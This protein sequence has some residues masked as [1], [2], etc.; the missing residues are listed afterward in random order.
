MYGR[1]DSSTFISGNKLEGQMEGVSDCIILSSVFK[2]V[3][4]VGELKCWGMDCAYL[5]SAVPTSCCSLWS[6]LY[7]KADIRQKVNFLN[8]QR[9]LL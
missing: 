4:L 8:E 5:V 2:P 6:H 3:S 1:G 9:R 7:L